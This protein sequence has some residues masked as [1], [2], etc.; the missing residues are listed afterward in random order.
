[1]VNPRSFSPNPYSRCALARRLGV[2]LRRIAVPAALILLFFTPGL[3]REKAPA[4][5]RLKASGGAETFFSSRYVSRGIA[6]GSEDTLPQGR[7]GF[8][9]LGLGFRF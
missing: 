1:M 8:S 9:G 4:D 3:A 5:A 2:G 6:S 7:N